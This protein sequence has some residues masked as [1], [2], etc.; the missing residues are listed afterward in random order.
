MRCRYAIYTKIDTNSYYG[1]KNDDD[2]VLEKVEH[3][4]EEEMRGNTL[5]KWQRIKSMC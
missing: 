5:R 3:P 4:I 1:Y 2:G